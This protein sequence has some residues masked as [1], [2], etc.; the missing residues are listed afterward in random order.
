MWKDQEKKK[1]KINWKKKRERWE[2]QK[3]R[4]EADTDTVLWKN[5][6]LKKHL[7]WNLFFNKVAD[8]R[9]ATLLIKIIQQKGVPVSFVKFLKTPFL[10][11]HIQWL[12]YKGDLRPK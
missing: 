10:I 3:H 1:Q 7:V 4:T 11:E 6:F 8:L 12:L 9:F 5:E 2:E